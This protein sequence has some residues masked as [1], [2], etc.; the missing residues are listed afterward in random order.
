MATNLPFSNFQ[1]FK[2]YA[3]KL[4]HSPPLNQYTPK[5]DAFWHKHGYK[6]KLGFFITIISIFV[7]LGIS[8]GLNLAAQNRLK[9]VTPPPINIPTISPTPVVS[10]RFDGVRQKIQTFSTLLPDPAPPTV[11]E[12]IRFSPLP[13]ER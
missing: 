1:E 5:I 8:L 9:A 3:V 12:N 6:V 11:D 7:I 4:W 10:S 2:S 13:E